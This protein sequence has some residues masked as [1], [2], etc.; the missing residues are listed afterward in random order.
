MYGGPTAP[1]FEALTRKTGFVVR[2]LQATDA[3][4][5][6][7]TN[8]RATLW[9]GFDNAYQGKPGCFACCLDG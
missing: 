6:V 9:E 1:C 2:I 4:D 5:M 8:V 7:H 3:W